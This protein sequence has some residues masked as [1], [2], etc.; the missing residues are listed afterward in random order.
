MDKAKKN[1]AIITA[2]VNDAHQAVE[3]I[4]SGY[5]A[6]LN[7]HWHATKTIINLFFKKKISKLVIYF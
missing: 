3:Q 4:A 6:S 2:V 5:F 7:I 1:D